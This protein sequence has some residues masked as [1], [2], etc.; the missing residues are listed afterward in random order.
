MHLIAARHER[1]QPRNPVLTDVPGRDLR[2]A[3]QT[4]R[5]ER[6]RHVAH[7]LAMLGRGQ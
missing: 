6:V 1:H 4:G 7:P 2:E 3:R 5:G